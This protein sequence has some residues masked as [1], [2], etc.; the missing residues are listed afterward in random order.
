MVDRAR[1]SLGERE[2]IEYSMGRGTVLFTSAGLDFSKKKG[3]KKGKFAQRVGFN[4]FSAESIHSR[5]AQRTRV[6]EKSNGAAG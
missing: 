6:G 1:F 3:E 5:R 2:N 4:S